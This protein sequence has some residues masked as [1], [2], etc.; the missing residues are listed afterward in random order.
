[1]HLTIA[2]ACL[3]VAALPG[4]GWAKL[5]AAA[6]TANSVTLTWTA[7]GDDGSSGTASQYDIRYSTSTITDANWNSATQV[8]GEP[9]PQIAGSAESMDVT[10][11]DPATTY[12]FAIKAGDE[13]PN[14]SILSNI[15]IKTT[16]QEDTPPSYIANLS[17]GSATVNSLRLSWNAPGDDGNSGTASE[18]DIRYS[19]S[20]ITDANWDAATQVSGEPSPQ[21]AGSSESFVVTGLAENTTYYFAI[22][23]A[24]EVPNWST[25]SNVPSASTAQESTA[26]AAIAALSAGS[27]T[28][29]SIVLSWTAPGDDGNTGTASQYD[30][31]YSGSAITDANWDAATQVSGEPTPQPA[32]SSESFTVT[33]LVENTTCYFAIKTADEVPNWSALSNVCSGTT[34]QESTA[35]SALADLSVDSPTLNSLTLHFTAP[36]D[37]GSVG[38]ASE[39]D[40]RY[41]TGIITAANFAGA[42]QVTGEPSPQAAGSSEAIEITGLTE[43]TTYYF[44]VKTAD[45]VPNW[46]AISNVVSASTADEVTPPAVVADLVSGSQTAATVTLSW[47]APGDDG[48]SGTA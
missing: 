22:K 3:L 38:T 41:S 34:H 7:P 40:I 37:D 9:T 8:T 44:A 5:V 35:P 24:D 15:A 21:I 23:T 25:L 43:N 11:L 13:V 20:T 42:T 17:L 29:T 48:T 4:T 36:G 32:G 28:E 39:Y 18:Y 47:T 14:W 45:E 31:R 2:A 46:S 12:Y 33:G 30:I 27:P 10:G 16:A 19:T 26:P 6:P 1:M